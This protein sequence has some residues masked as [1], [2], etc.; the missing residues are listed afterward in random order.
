MPQ[1]GAAEGFLCRKVGDECGQV[2][3]GSICSIS[4]KADTKSMCLF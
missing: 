4:L 2:D 1:E 3:P